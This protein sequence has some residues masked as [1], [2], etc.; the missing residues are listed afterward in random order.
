MQA[1]FPRQKRPVEAL[2]R[3]L[4]LVLLDNASA[5]YTFIVRFF[6]APPETVP[7]SRLASRNMSPAPSDLA[8]STHAPVP[9]HKFDRKDST[10]SMLSVNHSVE[11]NRSPVAGPSPRLGPDDSISEAGDDPTIGRRSVASP[12]PRP[13]S[14]IARG[15]RQDSFVSFRNGS[16]TAGSSPLGL[17][18]GGD[19]PKDSKREMEAIWHQVFDPA[20]EYCEV[21]ST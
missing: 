5:E 15:G 8:S 14:R 13:A 19:L 9:A 1:D 7:S 10:L 3:S 12:I 11:G 6:S 21:R 16:V 2:F 4:S 17:S 18:R 20:L